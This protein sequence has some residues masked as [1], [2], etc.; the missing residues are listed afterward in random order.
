M[1]SRGG[2]ARALAAVSLLLVL[3]GAA[4]GGAPLSWSGDE[5]PACAFPGPPLA[6]LAGVTSVRRCRAA[7]A[8]TARCVA[9]SFDA[10]G[11]CVLAAGA[12]RTDAAPSTA[13]GARCGVAPDWSGR[14]WAAGC[15]FAPRAANLTGG[16]AGAAAPTSAGGCRRLCVRTPGCTHYSWATAGGCAMHGGAGARADARTAAGAGAACG[17]VAPRGAPPPSPAPSPAPS[18]RPGN[19]SAGAGGLGGLMG[20]CYDPM[21]NPEY[22]LNGGPLGDLAAAMAKDFAQMASLGVA[23]ARTY[24]STFYGTPVAPAAAAAG[25][26]LAL[27]VFM[28]GE[29]W[30]ADQVAAAV[31]A[32]VNH[33]STV[34]ALLVGNEN[35]APAGPA[36]AAQIVARITGLRDALAAAGVAPGAVP[37]GTVQRATEWLAPPGTPGGDAAAA[38]AAACDVVGAN[39]YAFFG[40]ADPSDPAKPLDAQWTQLQA[41]Y[42]AKL[43][44]TETGF[45]SDG[46]TSPSGVPATLAG[47][48]GYW[49]A[50][51]RGWVP[52]G[53]TGGRPAFYFSMYDRRPD[54]GT[55]GGGYE[56]HFGLL[57]WD[58]R[59][60]GLLHPGGAMLSA[61]AGKRR[62]GPISRARAAALA[63][64][65]EAPGGD[66]AAPRR[67]GGRCRVIGS[68]SAS[69]PEARAACIDMV[70]LAWLHRA[71][72]DMAISVVAAAVQ[73]GQLA[74]LEW[75][76]GEGLDLRF[77]VWV[78]TEHGQVAVLEWAR[79]EGLDLGDVCVRA[80][81]SRQLAVLHWARAQTPPLP[82]GG[83][84][85]CYWAAARGDLEML[86]WARAQAEPAPWSEVS[87]YVAA[88]SGQLEALRWLRANGCP[89]ERDWC[90]RAAAGE[91]HEAV[92]AWIRAQP[93]AG[94]RG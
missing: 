44:L 81:F 70:G 20:V 18:P 37:V 15:S 64:W 84:D 56:Q 76:R 21:H 1:D 60:K 89:W 4:S 16:G 75:A 8:A 65:C 74:V 85:V 93:A 13:P 52:A 3:A 59:D 36:S 19:A 39:V 50:V 71:G 88:G 58:R 28:T 40:A 33:P 49:D 31:A 25:V 51:S 12:G 45:P 9:Y 68:G 43:Q 2:G 83:G 7:C 69:S 67:R 35:L 54:D 77:V 66:E 87:C 22:P 79:D 62:A 5:A 91:G 6:E 11:A 42:G 61:P 90:A 26:R 72:C 29:A 17:V 86:R 24:Y 14:A 48:R 53:R 94:D 80:A 82:W 34:T 27:G 57:T 92:A 73:H 30:Y 38:L 63:A 78:A 23:H 55:M 46:G 41:R 47:A 10:S 32:V